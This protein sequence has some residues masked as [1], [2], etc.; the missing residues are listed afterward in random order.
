ME[1]NTDPLT[2]LRAELV[3]AEDLNVILA[4][5]CKRLDA[6]V[7]S[8]GWPT[9]ACCPADLQQARN[10]AYSAHRENLHSSQLIEN[11]IGLLEDTYPGESA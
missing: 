10:L 11:V 9:L 1:T 8:I 4:E 7:W 5:R 3:A 2:N 6:L